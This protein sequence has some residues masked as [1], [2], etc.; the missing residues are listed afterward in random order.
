MSSPTFPQLPY[1]LAHADPTA[2][3][4]L[5]RQALLGDGF[6]YLTNIERVLP[7]W[8]TLW[9]EAFSESKAFFDLPL[10]QKREIEMANSRH[11]RGYSAVGVEIT[12]GKRDLREQIDLGSVFLTSVA[13]VSAERA[14]QTALG[15]N[16]GLPF[17][18][19]FLATRRAFAVRPESVPWC[20]I[21]IRERHHPISECL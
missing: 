7:E 13:E 17:Q 4:V 18:H 15:A 21:S 8:R 3:N 19:F 14:Q 6:F 11:F 9:D 12:A 16:R 2:F 1:E 20:C 10:E 5:L